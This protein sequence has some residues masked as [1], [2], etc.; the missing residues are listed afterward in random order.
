[1]SMRWKSKS[2]RISSR[3]RSCPVSRLSTTATFFAPCANKPRTNA[4]P[5]KPAPPVTKN[6]LIHS[7]LYNHLACP[8]NVISGDHLQLPPE[9]RA[10]EH[11]QNALDCLPC[12]IAFMQHEFKAFRRERHE[13]EPE[14]ARRGAGG[15][16]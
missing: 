13:V 1:M 11:F 16:A 10:I 4:D 12:H 3:F 9:T 6:R 7:S 15:D 8:R 2:P 14:A 5:M